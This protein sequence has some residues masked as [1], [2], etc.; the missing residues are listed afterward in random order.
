MK[1]K[2]LNRRNK[3]QKSIKPNWIQCTHRHTIDHLILYGS[4]Y[5]PYASIIC[6][7]LNADKI[8]NMHAY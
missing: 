4:I 5:K 7:H 1:K 8:Q 2:K 3:Q 6:A